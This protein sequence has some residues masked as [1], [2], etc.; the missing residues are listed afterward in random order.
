MRCFRNIGKDLAKAISREE[1]KIPIS[2][3]TVLLRNKAEWFSSQE[4]ELSK[5]NSFRNNHVFVWYVL[6]FSD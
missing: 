4:D 3:M 1:L 2:K 6:L 5:D